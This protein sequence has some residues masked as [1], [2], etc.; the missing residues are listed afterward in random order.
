MEDES[1]VIRKLGA[2]FIEHL[3]DKALRQHLMMHSGRLKG[4]GAMQLQA[5]LASLPPEDKALIMEIVTD[6][7]DTALH[8][9]LFAFQ[10]AHDHRE[11]IELVVDEKS[12]AAISGMLHGEIF[13]PKGWISNF[14]EFGPH[15]EK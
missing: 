5:R 1:P 10:E 11:G 14:S 7:L 15:K 12:P 6:V 9:L 4:K 8:D 13:G 2:F 3:R